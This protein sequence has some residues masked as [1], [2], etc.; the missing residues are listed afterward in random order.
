MDFIVGYEIKTSQS[1]HE[2]SDIC[3]ELAG[4]YP[5]DFQWTG[6]H[7]L[8]RCYSIPIIKT[9]KEYLEDAPSASEVKDVP[10]NFK[11]W[12]EDNKERIAAARERGTEPYF[13]RDNAQQ[14]DGI[15]NA[16]NSANVALATSP[17]YAEIEK[18]LGVKQGAP[19]TFEEANEMR[20]NPHYSEAVSY[21]VNCQT[22]VVA[23]ELRRRGFPVEAL[24]NTKGSTSELLSHATNMAWVTDEGV[25]PNKIH[26]GGSVTMKGTKIIYP[27]VNWKQFAEATKEPGRYHVDWKW[28]GKRD[29]HI[30]TFERFEDGTA[31]WYDPQNGAVNFMTK[32]YAARFNT[33]AVLRVDNLMP[34]PDICSKILAKS[35]SKAIG[36]E[37]AIDGTYNSLLK[38]QRKQI[39]KNAKQWARSNM[40]KVVL[41]N[42]DS[43]YRSTVY[44]A[45]GSKIIVNQSYFGEVYA[46][47]LKRDNLSEI[48][49]IAKDYSKWISRAKFVCQEAGKH[50]D[51]PFNVYEVMVN[52]KCIEVKTKLTDAEYLYTI[53]IK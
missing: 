42:G 5:K 32:A 17:Q 23:N 36:G 21:R 47:N 29:G 9:D 39:L 31:R 48:M 20:G 14:V 40:P 38:N 13:L 53:C 43:A 52:G 45:A 7:P 46:N 27:K 26:I 41:K 50:H 10:N 4:K 12:V 28:K 51:F 33:M 15:L 44:N 3:D 1:N 37:A 34:N 22:C 35:G 8:C 2:V 6:W 11:Q 25:A 19:M 49:D 18:Q 16:G 30:V 24:A